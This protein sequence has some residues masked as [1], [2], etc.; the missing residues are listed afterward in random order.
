MDEKLVRAF[1]EKNHA[2]ILEC[3]KPLFWKHLKGVNPQQQPDFLQELSLLCI[4]I[5][6]AYSFEDI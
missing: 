4:N 6:E 1:K 5:V 3:L 2:Y